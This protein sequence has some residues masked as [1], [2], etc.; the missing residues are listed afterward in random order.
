MS[1]LALGLR[2]SWTLAGR[3]LRRGYAVPAQFV[4]ALAFPVVFTLL[5]GYVFGSGMTVPGG[6]DYIAFLMPGLF[7]QM[8]AFGLVG[9]MSEVAGD[10]AKGIT[11]RFRSLPIAAAAVVGGRSVSD[12]ANAVLGLA[13]MVAM[14]LLM[15]WSWT[16]G[17]ADAAA[18]I[19][20]L[21]LLRFALLWIGIYLGLLARDPEAVSGL[22]LL[23]FPVT[24]VTS[25]FVAPELMPGW[26]GTIAEWNPLSATIGAT[27][28]LFGNPGAATGGGWPAQHAQLLAV[29][30]P[31]VLVAVF[32]PLAARRYRAMSR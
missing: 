13:V 30:W 27:R 8:T 24:M 2:D 15:G 3:N 23:T 4:P 14:G 18:A 28:E 22:F 17:A 32:L 7:V 5:Y 16:R 11:D 29:L 19:G 21:L 25:A 6:G 31:L 9:T 1:A 10:A 20:L 26:L 12:M